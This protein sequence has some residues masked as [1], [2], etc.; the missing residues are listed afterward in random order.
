M[1]VLWMRENQKSIN[2]EQTLLHVC[3]AYK[4]K[5]KKIIFN[6]YSLDESESKSLHISVNTSKVN[7]AMNE[8]KDEEPLVTYNSVINALSLTILAE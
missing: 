3:S 8:T 4:I 7:F 6:A 2:M 1:S 5:S